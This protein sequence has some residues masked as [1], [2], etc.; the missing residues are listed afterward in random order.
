MTLS[1]TGSFYFM[2]WKSFIL[3][4]LLLASLS[5][6]AQ[7]QPSPY[8]LLKK[9]GTQKEVVFYEGDEIRFRIRGEDHY[10]RA[11]IQ[12]LRIDTVRFHY[13]EVAIRDIEVIDIRGHRYQHFHFASAGSK[14]IAAGMLFLAGDYV[15]QKL[16]QDEPGGLSTQTWAIAGSI[17][18]AGLIL[19][20]FQKRRFR[21]GGRYIIDIIDMRPRR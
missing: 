19:K 3:I 11:L 6:L 13:F 8:L 16:I 10:R 7:S 18:G 4:C 21:P 2:S 5:S 12:G 9:A 17:V 1:L 15:N 14:V 20:L